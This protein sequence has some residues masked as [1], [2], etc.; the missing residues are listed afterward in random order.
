[1]A[2]KFANQEVVDQVLDMI[3][4]KGVESL[5]PQDKK[6][7]AFPDRPLKASGPSE[8]ALHISN[9]FLHNPMTN[10]R[11]NPN[12]EIRNEIDKE[13]LKLTKN[14]WKINK[15]YH[16][17]DIDKESEQ[18]FRM[19]MYMQEKWGDVLNVHSEPCT[20]LG[21]ACSA[22]KLYSKNGEHIMTLYVPVDYKIS[23]QVSLHLKYSVF[24][25]LEDKFSI[26]MSRMRMDR[27]MRSFRVWLA[28]AGLDFEIR[29]FVR[30]RNL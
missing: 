2:N 25:D 28:L 23:H 10:P 30:K 21:R 27:E 11:F 8:K 1:M 4:E 24:S 16:T 12:D 5:T 7:L 14:E 17:H 22:K 3:L 15:D 6:V 13:I 26:T 20:Y 29:G 19:R 18:E 9:L